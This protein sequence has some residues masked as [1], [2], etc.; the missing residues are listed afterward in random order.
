MVCVCVLISS[1]NSTLNV[2]FVGKEEETITSKNST[3]DVECVGKGGGRISS[4][5]YT[6]DVEFVDRESKKSAGRGQYEG[7]RREERCQDE[8]GTLT[9]RRLRGP[10]KVVKKKVDRA[11]RS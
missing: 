8:F 4:K 1:K 6:L 2:E 5:N 11:L 3:L 9:G 10:E 7:L